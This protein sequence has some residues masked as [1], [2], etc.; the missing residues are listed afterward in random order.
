MWFV[1]LGAIVGAIVGY[2]ACCLADRID[3]DGR[4][5]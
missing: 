5:L 2:L 3:R 1:I 4:D